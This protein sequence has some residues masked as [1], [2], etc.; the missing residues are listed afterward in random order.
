MTT[1]AQMAISFG[2]LLSVFGLFYQ[3]HKDSKETAQKIQ[4]METEIEQLK[5][6]KEEIRE[7]KSEIADMK[8]DLN[9]LNQVM[10]RIDTNVSHIM[11][12]K[13]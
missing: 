4:K 8:H 7:I 12:T 5:A 1:E 2:S 9:S 3:W 13:K 11:N 10:T 6:H